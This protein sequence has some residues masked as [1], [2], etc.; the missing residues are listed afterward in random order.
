MHEI[1]LYSQIAPTRH[2]QVLNVLAG[3]TGSQPFVYQDQTALFAQ[4]R[5]P[6]T[7]V[8][9]KKKPVPGTPRPEKWVHK[10]TRPVQVTSDPP[11]SVGSWRV[12]VDQ[13]PDPSVKDHTAREVT[14]SEVRDVKTF[15][16]AEMYLFLGQQYFLGHRFVTG[17]V[18]VRIFRV[19]LT[20]QQL[21]ADRVLEGPPLPLSKLQLLD[22][23]NTYMVEVSVRMEDRKNT[24]IAEQAIAEL[25]QFQ[26]AVE[27]VIDLRVPQR[28][29]LDTRV[30]GA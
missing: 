9:S 6:E 12:R 3:V 28:L 21:P 7:T 2:N 18:I 30:K 15:E 24:K 17:N 25:L 13:I 16:D 4:L 23:S 26:N 27:G 29:A 10:L 19:L 20:Q 14:E 11:E 5:L 8:S 1:L 22:P